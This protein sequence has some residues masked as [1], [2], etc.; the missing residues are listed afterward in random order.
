MSLKTWIVRQFGK[1]AGF[2]GRLA[3][4]I[5]ARRSSNRMRNARTVEMMQLTPGMRVLEVGCGPGLALVDCAMSVPDGRVTGLDHSSVMI[6]QAQE[7]LA[8]AG[9]LDRVELVGGGIEVLDDN[10]QAFDRAFSLNVIQFLPDK[11]AYFRAIHLQLAP[12]GM[13][14]TT[15]QPRLEK[16]ARVAVA[17]QSDAIVEAMRREGFEAIERQTISAGETQAICVSGRSAGEHA[18]SA[19]A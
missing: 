5:M 13:V 16:D 10:A 15:Y 19:P 14:F 4:L 8:K 3:G 1:P 7:R 18:G 9:L 17:S 11:A 2:P 6:R 12:G